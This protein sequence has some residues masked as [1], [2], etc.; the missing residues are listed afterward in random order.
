MGLLVDREKLNPL[1]GCVKKQETEAETGSKD[2]PWLSLQFLLPASC[3]DFLNNS[4]K[5][6]PAQV[7]FSQCFIIDT[8]EHTGDS[9]PQKSFQ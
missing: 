8:G 1:V 4:L 2:P 6:S 7:V 5:P 3:L 9:S